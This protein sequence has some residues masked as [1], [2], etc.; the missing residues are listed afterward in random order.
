VRPLLISVCLSVL[1]FAPA[2]VPGGEKTSAHTWN[3]RGI[4]LFQEEDYRRA[5]TCF[6]EAHRAMPEDETIQF[7]LASAHARLAMKLVRENPG[8]LQL[9]EA[10]MEAEHA[11]ALQP[12]HP[13]FQNVLGFVH[14]ERGEPGEA[15]RAYAR[16]AELDPGDGGTRVL[17]GNAAYQ[18]DDLEGAI[19][20]W[21]SAL[22]LEP[23][24]Q[25]V[26]SRLEKAERERGIEKNY[27]LLRSR[28]FRMR[29]DP[30]YDGGEEKAER[31]I[32]LLEEARRTVRDALGRTPTAP[33]SVV[34]YTPGDF[35]ELM[36]AH[37]WTRGLYDGKIRLP[38]LA[39]GESEEDLRKLTVHEYVHVV[40]YDWTEDRCPAWLN[41]GLAQFIAGE[42]T[43]DRERRLQMLMAEPSW[44][45]LSELEASFLRLPES[46]V[47]NAYIEAHVVTNHL[48]AFYTKR[49]LELLLDRLAAGTPPE[50]ALQ[51]AYHRSYA[52][53]LEEAFA[54]SASGLASR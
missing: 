31:M 35:R 16:A 24:Q 22:R 54:Q 44:L 9:A 30:A 40:I 14:Q 6:G 12:E 33:V 39:E 20:H 17:M 5:L 34:V 18:L 23:D 13:F 8:R 52:R 19:D 7:N 47:E 15:L 28:H 50:E 3:D 46:A 4:R 37:H 1:L 53:I 26:V 49:H 48:L 43:P 45:P 11:V 38:F 27:R 2:L 41:E 25:E 21:Q 51:G 29:Y 36:G 10:L 42:W 32:D